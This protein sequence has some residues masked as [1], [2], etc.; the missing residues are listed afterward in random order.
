MLVGDRDDVVVEGAGGDRSLGLVDE[1]GALRDRGREAARP[2]GWPPHAGGPGRRRR[3]RRRRRSRRPARRGAAA[4][5]MW[6]AAPSSPNV[7]GTGGWTAKCALVGEG[8]AELGER[9]GPFV[10]AVRHRPQIGDGEV[11]AAVGG[12]GGGRDGRGIGRPHRRG[13][14]SGG[15]ERRRAPPRRR[16]PSAASQ[17]RSGRRCGRNRPWARPRRRLCRIFARPCSAAARGMGDEALV[18]RRGEIAEA[19]AGI[20][21]ARP[22]DAVEI[23]LDAAPS[24]ADRE[25]A[26]AGRRCRA[27]R[28]PRGDRRR[29]AVLARSRHSRVAGGE[30]GEPA[31]GEHHARSPPDRRRSTAAITSSRASR[32]V[33]IWSV[34]ATIVGPPSKMSI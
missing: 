33:R 24:A 13:G 22:D 19:E 11:A 15:A 17:A 14:E 4:S 28:R 16:S 21:V 31:G 34:A 2:P 23:D 7:A 10:A 20:I 27:A 25:E 29:R 6:L 12:V 32:M 5:R 8:E 3:A 30:T 26:V 9:L 18:G 1:Q